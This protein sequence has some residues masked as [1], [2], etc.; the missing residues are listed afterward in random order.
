MG[1]IIRVGT[2]GFSY[3]DW[4]GV[5]YPEGTPKSGMLAHYA[6]VFDSLEI[7]ATYYGTPSKASARTMLE[8]AHGRV[9]F[10]IKAPGAMTHQGDLSREVLL[11]WLAFLEPFQDAEMLAAVLVQFPAR[12]HE[13]QGAWE[14]LARVRSA[15]KGCPLVFEFR[16]AT[17]DTEDVARRLTDQ[18][19]SRSWVDQP[20]IK[21]L[22]QSGIERLTGDIAYIRFHGRNAADWYGEVENSD[23]YLY[24]YAD[25]ELLPFVGPLKQVAARAK[26]TLA[27][28]NNHPKGNA[29]NDAKTFSRMLGLEERGQGDLF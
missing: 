13:T 16:H 2:S 22:S 21:G 27:F 5:L 29:V 28:F 11:P 12:F 24:K 7:N 19:I 6:T 3:D 14:F 18:Q 20:G 9:V 17:W 8:R 26:T 1:S 25:Q 10:A 4:R 15:L 23:R